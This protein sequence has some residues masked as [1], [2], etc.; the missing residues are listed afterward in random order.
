MPPIAPENF[1]ALCGLFTLCGLALTNRSDVRQV[2]RSRVR[3]S[4]ITLFVAA[5]PGRTAML[6]LAVMIEFALGLLFMPMAPGSLLGIACVGSALGYTANVLF[7][8]FTVQQ[9]RD[10]VRHLRA[11]AAAALE[12]G[13]HQACDELDLGAPDR[14]IWGLCLKEANDDAEVAGTNYVRRRSRALARESLLAGGDWAAWIAPSLIPHA[15]RDLLEDRHPAPF[16][17]S[18]TPPPHDVS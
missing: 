10:A 4:A 2:L 12:A 15:F 14:R 16:A 13:N 1:T 5:L 11:D 9:G 17:T 18:T 7:L 6:V 8:I 3:A